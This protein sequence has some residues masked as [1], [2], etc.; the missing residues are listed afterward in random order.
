MAQVNVVVMPMGTGKTTISSKYERVV[1]IDEYIN[2]PEAKIELVPARMDALE[3]GDWARVTELTMKYTSVIPPDVLV[4]AHSIDYFKSAK[5]H[6]CYKLSWSETERRILARDG[7]ESLKLARTNWDS[8]NCVISTS[9]EIEQGILAILNNLG[10]TERVTEDADALLEF[11]RNDKDQDVLAEIDDIVHDITLPQI[12]TKILHCRESEVSVV[13][14][15]LIAQGVPYMTESVLRSRS[16]GRSII[17][18]DADIVW[19][20]QSLSHMGTFQ[21]IIMHTWIDWYRYVPCMIWSTYDK[22]ADR[23]TSVGLAADGI[24]SYVP[25]YYGTLDHSKN[26]HVDLG[27]CLREVCIMRSVKLGLPLT[28][29]GSEIES[30]VQCWDY[31]DAEHYGNFTLPKPEDADPLERASADK[32]AIPI[33]DI[34]NR[35]GV[36]I[37]KFER[38][39]RTPR[40]TIPGFILYIVGSTL[41]YIL[42]D[43][44]RTYDVKVLRSTWYGKG[45]AQKYLLSLLITKADITKLDPVNDRLVVALFALSNTI[46]ERDAYINVMRNK[47][48]VITLPYRRVHDDVVWKDKYSDHTYLPTQLPPFLDVPRYIMLH[49]DRRD[50][51]HGM[52]MICEAATRWAVIADDIVRVDD[53]IP[54]FNVTEWS[55]VLGV[56][57]R[58]RLSHTND[59]LHKIRRY[60]ASIYGVS[61]IE[62]ELFLDDVRVEPAGHLINIML[63]SHIVPIDVKSYIHLIEKNLAGHVTTV[64]AFEREKDRLQWHT[65][66][67]WFLGYQTYKRLAVA[68]GWKPMTLAGRIN[69]VGRVV[70][71]S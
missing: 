41:H 45:Y 32:F 21:V 22:R 35:A 11:L 70:A 42:D 9:N 69:S 57:M 56:L 7:R 43:R 34:A 38:Y 2:T 15:L 67:D 14:S 8:V 13:E 44:K 28:M 65:E 58:T 30:V 63:S 29:L 25:V 6:A 55:K 19:R 37:V 10:F 53:Q 23:V 31:Q 27:R 12:Q 33:Q 71:Q 59:T 60:V 49:R 54:P 16:R 1:D 61:E 26:M 4:L 18:E 17:D 62:G 51:A 52:N 36:K 50:G 47:H 48:Y 64:T 66:L 24:T 5:L 68:F 40:I 46:N 3:N 39:R 20:L